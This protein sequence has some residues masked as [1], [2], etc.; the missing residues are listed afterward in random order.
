[1]GA[2]NPHCCEREATDGLSCHLANA[3]EKRAAPHT[4]YGLAT[5]QSI[6]CVG[7]LVNFASDNSKR[8]DSE[9]K[10]RQLIDMFSI[11]QN[12]SDRPKTYF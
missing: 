5:L 3:V 6:R 1:V 7:T 10:K 12:E 4:P 8:Y 2:Q 11:R 9:E